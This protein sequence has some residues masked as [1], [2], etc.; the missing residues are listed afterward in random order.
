M[1]IEK[2]WIERLD[3]HEDDNNK[4]V[5]GESEKV[6]RVW[7]RLLDRYILTKRFRKI[8]FIQQSLKICILLDTKRKF[9]ICE[10]SQLNSIKFHSLKKSHNNLNWIP[11]DLFIFYKSHDWILQN[12]FTTKNSFKISWNLNSINPQKSNSYNAAIIT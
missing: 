7:V 8:Y 9:I 3:W 11:Y 6:L 1:I 4:K 2:N 10:N 5:F 12:C